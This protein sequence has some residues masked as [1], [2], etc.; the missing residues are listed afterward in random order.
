MDDLRITGDKATPDTCRLILEGRIT[1]VTSIDLNYKL[2]Q[3]RK[4]YKHIIVN[5]QK[6]SFLSSGG[7][8]VLL[9]FFKAMK[10]EGGSFYIEKPSENVKNVLGMTALNEM[11]LK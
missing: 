3:A 11:L 5:M 6:V 2:S 7:I 10:G 1:S 9:M 4:E 8:R